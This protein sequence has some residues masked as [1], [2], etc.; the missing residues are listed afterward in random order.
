LLCNDH[1]LRNRTTRF[2]R[3]LEQG[4]RRRH[5]RKF[6]GHEQVGDL[7]LNQPIRRLPNH[8]RLEQRSGAEQLG[9]ERRCRRWRRRKRQLDGGNHPRNLPDSG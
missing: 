1:Q 6:R 2:H 8:K 7:E 5:L 3:Q 9:I 4:S